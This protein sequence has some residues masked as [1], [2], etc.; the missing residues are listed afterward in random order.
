M[1]KATHPGRYAVDINR[2]GTLR[3]QIMEKI[4]HSSC[5]LTFLGDASSD[6]SA[7][8]TGSLLCIKGSIKP[9]EATASGCSSSSRSMRSVRAICAASSSSSER[10]E[11]TCSRSKKLASISDHSGSRGKSARLMTMKSKATMLVLILVDDA[12]AAL[13]SESRSKLIG[14]RE[15]RCER[16]VRRVRYAPMRAAT[17]RASARVLWRLAMA[18][19]ARSSSKVAS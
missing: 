8:M 19:E 11:R 10:R 18:S 12:S 3:R 7:Q 16:W 5:S 6:S 1:G 15:Y 2:N 4:A 13:A 9:P 17:P 14:L